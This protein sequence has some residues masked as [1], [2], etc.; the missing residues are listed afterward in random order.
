MRQSG[1]PTVRRRRLAAELRRLRERAE[2]TIEQVAERLGWS[3]TKVSRIETSRVGV[4]LKDVER[5]VDLYEVDDAKRKELLDLARDAQKK[6]WWHAYGDLPS[7]YATYIGLE[8]EAASMRSFAPSVIPGILQTEDYARAIIRS[9]LM[10]LSSPAEVE[11]RVEVRMARQALLT[12]DEPL[13]LWTIL[14]EAVIRR[15][16]GSPADMRAQLGRLLELVDLPNITVQVLPFAAGAHPGTNG[17]FQILEFPEPAHPDV[18]SL[19]NFTG[20]LYVEQETDVYRYT[21]MFDHL[22]AKAL[23]PDQSRSVLTETMTGLGRSA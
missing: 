13:R 16:I 5:L 18:V 11:R 12:Q 7:E 2:M 17:A 19:E 8:D 10:G 23:D 22:R 1:S 4:A 20:S 14:D 15:T 3:A 6:G 9:A 21:V